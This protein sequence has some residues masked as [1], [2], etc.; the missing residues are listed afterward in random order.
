MGGFF[1]HE[2][3]CFRPFVRMAIRASRQN[4]TNNP[5]LTNKPCS[6][7]VDA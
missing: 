5:I 4:E 6:D 7:K 3:G 2:T 1:Q